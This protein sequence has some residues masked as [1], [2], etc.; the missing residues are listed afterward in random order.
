MIRPSRRRCPVGKI[1]AA[2][3]VGTGVASHSLGRVRLTHGFLCVVVVLAA[4]C[5][6]EASVAPLAEPA[7]AATPVATRDCPA[8]IQCHPQWRSCRC[9]FTARGDVAMMEAD[10]DGDGRPNTRMSYVYDAAGNLVRWD[11][12]QGA[13]GT[14]DMP[15]TFEPPCPPPHPNSAC[16]CVGPARQVTRDYVEQRLRQAGDT[17]QEVDPA[18]AQRLIDSVQARRRST[19]AP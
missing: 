16:S 12:D 19:G 3:C 4:G 14:V 6:N 8:Y 10:F 1:D 11:N 15:C 9:T 7:T 2:R 5:R 13:D 18:E 17:A